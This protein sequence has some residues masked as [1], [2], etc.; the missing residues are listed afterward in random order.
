MNNAELKKKIVERL[1]EPL[2]EA[3][4]YV[5]KERLLRCELNFS[6]INPGGVSDWV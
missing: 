3:A 2:K 5:K 1:R 6:D 4:Q